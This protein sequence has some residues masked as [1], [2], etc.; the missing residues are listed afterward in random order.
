MKPFHF[1]VLLSKCRCEESQS[2][3][4]CLFK[5]CQDWMK[6]IMLFVVLTIYLFC[7]NLPLELSY[8]DPLFSNAF[9][10]STHDYFWINELVLCVCSYSVKGYY[11]CGIRDILIP[12]YAKSWTIHSSLIWTLYIIRTKKRFT[13]IFHSTCNS[14]MHYPRTSGSLE[15]YCEHWE[16][17]MCWIIECDIT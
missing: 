16:V 1:R 2:E 8:F 3:I 17:L 4:D 11:F 12:I 9:L 15:V 6:Y 5:F 10:L 7:H 14:L 13:Y